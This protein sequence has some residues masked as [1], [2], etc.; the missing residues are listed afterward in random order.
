MA[1]FPSPARAGTGTAGAAA[2]VVGAEA[3]VGETLVLRVFPMLVKLPAPKE[4][5]SDVESFGLAVVP[6]PALAH[7]GGGD[8]QDATNC[9][10][11]PWNPAGADIAVDVVPA[12]REGDWAVSAPG[13]LPG[14][15][16]RS[17]HH[18][19]EDGWPRVG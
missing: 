16:R 5:L 1:P 17:W 11:V 15:A 10:G 12:G 13:G 6:V 4:E 8:L 14:F 19:C 7:D 2:P 9:V 18:S 3:G